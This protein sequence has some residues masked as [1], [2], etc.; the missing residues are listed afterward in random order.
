MI[1]FIACMEEP[2]NHVIEWNRDGS[3]YIHTLTFSEMDHVS[4]FYK[5]RN[6]EVY[7]GYIC[8]N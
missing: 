1:S 4:N 5:R 2:L 6:A 8:F 3:R 7:I